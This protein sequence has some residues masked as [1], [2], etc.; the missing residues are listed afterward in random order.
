MGNIYWNKYVRATN[1]AGSF[2]C[3]GVD[4]ANTG[5]GG[6][7]VAWGGNGALS[8]NDALNPTAIPPSDFAI[9]AILCWN[10]HLDD[11]AIV[12][13]NNA[14]QAY[15]DTGLSSKS[16]IK[17]ALFTSDSLFLGNN[18]NVGNNPELATTSHAHL[19]GISSIK[20]SRRNLAN[21]ATYHEWMTQSGFGYYMLRQ[22]LLG[23]VMLRNALND[24]FK[25]NNNAIQPVKYTFRIFPHVTTDG[26]RLDSSDVINSTS[27]II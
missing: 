5:D 16:R 27:K 20:L 4:R 25:F 17:K 23:T 12:I 11:T 18:T 1:Y 7:D 8:I 21:N 24:N 9:S 14:F 15:L 19:D 26:I 13:V 22:N 10:Y 6:W 3:N 2:R